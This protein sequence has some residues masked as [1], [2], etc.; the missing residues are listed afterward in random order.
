MNKKIVFVAACISAAAAVSVGTTLAWLTSQSDTLVNTFTVGKI[1]MKLDEAN[2]SD[3]A[4]ISGRTESGNTYRIQDSAVLPKDPTVTIHSESEDCYVFMSSV[5][6]DAVD[7]IVSM[8]IDTEHWLEA[9]ENLYVYTQDGETP[10]IVTYSTEDTVLP[11]LFTQISFADDCHLSEADMSNA[12]ITVKALAYQSTSD[13]TYDA[14]L[15]EAKAKL[16]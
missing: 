8:N 5:P 10:S 9:D 11:A 6:T 1:T 3:N 7:G 14:A 4:V 12:N 15:T 16:L 2:V 13:K